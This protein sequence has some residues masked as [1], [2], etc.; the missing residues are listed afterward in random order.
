MSLLSVFCAKQWDSKKKQ[1]SVSALRIY[2]GIFHVVN[3]WVKIW[4]QKIHLY[5]CHHGYRFAFWTQ[6]YEHFSPALSM[7]TCFKSNKLPALVHSQYFPLPCCF[8]SL[9]LSSAH[10]PCRGWTPLIHSQSPLLWSLIPKARESLKL[11][12]FSV[13]SIRSNQGLG[14]F[15]CNCC[16]F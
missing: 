2:S 11:A 15:P 16:K 12:W 8:V 1:Y 7:Q 5:F 14:M 10:L 4:Q 6:T 13:Q 3:T 9:N